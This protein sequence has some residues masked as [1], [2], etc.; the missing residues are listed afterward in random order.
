MG[1]C[2]WRR[3]SSTRRSPS[4][5]T[6]STPFP[7]PLKRRRGKQYDFASDRGLLFEL[8]MLTVTTDELSRPMLFLLFH[9]HK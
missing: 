8:F 3:L 2:G 6:R 4:L 9:I 7:S 5:D 1:A